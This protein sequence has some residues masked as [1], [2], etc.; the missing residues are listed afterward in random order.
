[1]TL[2]APLL[3]CYVGHWVGFIVLW[4]SK[5]TNA[6]QQNALNFN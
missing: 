4:F 3:L 1:M 6:L 5:G 2:Y